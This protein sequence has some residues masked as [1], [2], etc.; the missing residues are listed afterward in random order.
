MNPRAAGPRIYYVRNMGEDTWE[1]DLDEEPDF[2]ELVRGHYAYVRRYLRYLGCSQEEADDLVQETFIEVW[3]RPFQYFGDRATRGF[4]R[5]VAKA[6]FAR[7][8]GVRVRQPRFLD[9]DAADEA[10]TT[11]F[12]RDDDSAYLAALATCLKRLPGRAQEALR[13]RYRN[14]LSRDQIGKLLGMTNE[15]IKT[16][17][18]RSRALLRTCIMR[19]IRPS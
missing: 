6:K 12:Q 7:W 15:G 8:A 13:L 3:K 10:W 14:D 1:T 18:R 2:S 17:M 9:L 19:S 5:C 4:L 16:L 11:V